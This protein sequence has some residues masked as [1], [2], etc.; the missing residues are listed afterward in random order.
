MAIFTWCLSSKY[1]KKYFLKLNGCGILIY[2]NTCNLETYNHWIS[3]HDIS[4]LM[5]VKQRNNPQGK[6]LIKCININLAS[7]YLGK[8]GGPD[9]VNTV[10]LLFFSLNCSFLLV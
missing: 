1:L 4:K 10:Q 2:L 9:G 7:C 3:E 8:I 5:L 6:S